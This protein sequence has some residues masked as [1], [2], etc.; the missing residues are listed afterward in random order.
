MKKMR[1]ERRR[2]YV[3]LV[4]APKGKSISCFLM[5]KQL[6]SAS[7]RQKASLV[8]F[9]LLYHGIEFTNPCAF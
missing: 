4:V 9:L 5:F 3:E 6:W 8:Q 1:L 7:W 2:V